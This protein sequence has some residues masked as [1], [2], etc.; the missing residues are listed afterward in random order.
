MNKMDVTQKNLLNK[1]FAE[2]AGA[3]VLLHRTEV[4]DGDIV[5]QIFM[6]CMR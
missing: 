2:F 6:S 4:E 3:H 1:R 5:Q